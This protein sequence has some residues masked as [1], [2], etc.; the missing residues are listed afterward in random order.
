MKKCTRCGFPKELTEFYYRNSWCKACFA[1]YQRERIERDPGH[2][3][4]VQRRSRFKR[5]YGIT[6]EEYAA[7]ARL[8][9]NVCA[10][11][12]GPQVAGRDFAVDHDHTTGSVR[13]LLCSN[14]NLGIGN[15][16]DDPELIALAIAYVHRTSLP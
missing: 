6:E 12:R 5:K 8:Q 14:C 15:F 11:C 3:R 13:G 16:R 4:T 10:I 7:M 9:G 1:D 2:F